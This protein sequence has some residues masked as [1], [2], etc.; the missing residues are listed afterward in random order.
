M[1]QKNGYGR[2][3][4]SA[5]QARVICNYRGDVSKIVNDEKRREHV[6]AEFAPIFHF[7]GIIHKAFTLTRGS[8]RLA[9][10][11]EAALTP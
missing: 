5:N 2:G 1:V 10:R 6:Y 9:P 11:R 8:R 4:K 7:W 3:A